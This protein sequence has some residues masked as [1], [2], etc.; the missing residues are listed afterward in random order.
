M[1]E[2]L[3]EE[4]IEVHAIAGSSMGAY[5]GSLWAAGF[6]GVQLGELAAE[7]NDSRQMWKLAD[8]LFPPLQGLFR[9]EKAKRH[10]AR[11]LGDLKFEDLERKLLVVTF[12]LDTAQRLVIQKGRIIDAVHDDYAAEQPEKAKLLSEVYLSAGAHHRGMSYDGL[13]MHLHVSAS[14]VDVWLTEIV[15]EVVVRASK[16]KLI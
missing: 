8:P 13:A 15:L 12:D 1:L 10:L 16:E 3:E 7:M 5:I 4:G 11:S 14:T 2:V 9:G 6:S